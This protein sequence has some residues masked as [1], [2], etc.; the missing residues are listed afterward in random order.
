MVKLLWN[1]ENIED[2]DDEVVIKDSISYLGKLIIDFAKSKD[3]IFIVAHNSNWRGS[4]GYK[5]LELNDAYQVG[6][7][8]FPEYDCTF[9]LY[10]DGDSMYAV[11]YSHDV[12]TGSV[13]DLI[14]MIDV[15]YFLDSGFSTVEEF[16]QEFEETLG[17]E[18]KDFIKNDEDKLTCFNNTITIF[19]DED[20]EIDY[21]DCYYDDVEEEYIKRLLVRG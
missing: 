20:E 3:H 16:K 18:L 15:E 2:I 14:P 10:Q 12:P 7:D 5:K 19:L 8:I 21:I 6:S 11:V 9:K 4:T 13:W 1:S 17:V